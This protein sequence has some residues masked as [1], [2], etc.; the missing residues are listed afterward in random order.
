M[1]SA[2]TAAPPLL[3]GLLSPH[4]VEVVHEVLDILVTVFELRVRICV[5]ELHG[6][7]VHYKVYV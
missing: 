4:T 1:A 2:A 6:Q 3:L 5:F 7:C